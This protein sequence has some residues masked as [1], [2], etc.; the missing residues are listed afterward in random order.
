MSKP[1]WDDVVDLPDELDDETAEQLYEEADERQDMTG[2]VCPYPQLEAK[3]A[4]Q[5]LGSGDL[6]VQETDHVPSTENVPK[7][8]EDLADAKVWKSGS[9]LYRIFLSKK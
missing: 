5:G 1:T 7:A 2:E 4:I 8:V 6:L 9:G 3:K